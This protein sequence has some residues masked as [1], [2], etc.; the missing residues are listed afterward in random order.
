MLLDDGSS[1][2]RE[3]PGSAGRRTEHTAGDAFALFR[4]DDR[5]LHGQVAL[6]WGR[7]LA[8]RRFL[9]VDDALAGDPRSIQ[10]YCL[11]APEGTEVEIRS[12]ADF[13]GS[14]RAGPLDRARTVLLV[15]GIETAGRLLRD[16]VPGPV[17][18]GGIHAR[19]GSREVLPY[20]HLLP[21]EER[22]ILDLL[23]E[24]HRF[25]AQDLPN[26]PRRDPSGIL[27]VHASGETAGSGE[28]SHG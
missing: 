3:V 24:G 20:L 5:L 11:S 28:G 22:L 7:A 1:G 2:P 12:E 19:V 10:V 27:D 8:P 14:F 6:A 18:L 4:V 23:A 21:A 26:N 16:G 9:L 17:N 25:F 13:L 15:R